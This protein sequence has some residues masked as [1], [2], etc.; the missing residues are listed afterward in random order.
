VILG[1]GRAR[2]RFCKFWFDLNATPTPFPATGNL[3][4]RNQSERSSSEL[5]T[6]E[7]LM[8]TLRQAIRTWT[9]HRFLS[10]A[11]AS[12]L[13]LG[14]GLST[15][16]FTVANSVVFRPL[17][18]LN[19]DRL[20]AVFEVN[21]RFG[22]KPL[23]VSAPDYKAWKQKALGFDGI[24]AVEI[25]LHNIRFQGT[26]Q[27]VEAGRAEPDFFSLL[28]VQPALGR[29][30]LEED[31]VPM[32]PSV[33]MLSFDCW[34]TRFGADVN[35]IGS[36][37]TVDDRLL[38]I[39]GVLPRTFYCSLSSEP[40]HPEVWIPLVPT[41]QEM[42]QHGP[43]ALKVFARLRPGDTIPQA[44]TAIGAISAQISA[45]HPDSGSGTG[46][47]VFPLQQEVVGRTRPALMVLIAAA[48]CL[49][50]IAC[51]DVSNLMLARAIDRQREMAVR[52]ALGARRSQLLRM[53]LIE[54]SLL[55]FAGGGAGV[56]L[57]FWSLPVI[58]R[59]VPPDVPRIDEVRI[60]WQ[61]LLFA[62]SVSLLVT[63]LFG[64]LPAFRPL[65]LNSLRGGGDSGRTVARSP[66]AGKVR[67]ALIVGQIALTLVLL[68][69][70][71]LMAN[72]LIRL[73]RVNP[74]FVTKDLF[75][76]NIGPSHHR[77][78]E[79]SKL[80]DFFDRV[81]EH[82]RSAPGVSAAAVSFPLP[83]TGISIK[84]GFT[85]EG[86]SDVAGEEREADFA[87]ISPDYFKT[88][89]IA[90]LKGRPLSERDDLASSQVAVISD[91]L[92]S[93]LWPGDEPIG[94]RIVLEAQP[95]ASSAQAVEV[96]GIAAD[97][98]PSPSE[99]PISTIY[100]SYR[101]NPW[102]SMYL[103]ARG[104]PGIVGLTNEMANSVN[105]IDDTRPL[106][107]MLSMDQRWSNLVVT[108]RFYMSVLGIFGLVALALALMGIYSLMTYL[109]SQRTRS[110][111]IRMAMGATPR[112]ILRLVVGEAVAL[113]M[114][115]AA[116][117][118]A[119][120]FWLTRLIAAFLF[121]I[122]PTD[123][124]TIALATISMIIMA[125]FASY[126]PARRAAGID[127]IE[128]LRSE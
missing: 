11:V 107:D 61:T 119:V 49:M 90:L 56:A 6:W 73:Y 77:I 108:P 126:F 50:L 42:A 51:A 34:R 106:G 8:F 12:S 55:A 63:I 28:G 91:T 113:A 125:L 4:L 38:T 16:I 19:P 101:Q 40:L 110:I 124:L 23:A 69:G 83:M 43:G 89:R 44:Q 111:G 76:M 122:Q 1:V 98:R 71:L 121:E 87:V 26:N 95:G 62:A 123:P 81:L 13:A 74:G 100:Q 48:A 9:T 102:P 67:G 46:V 24:S 64:V 54:S 116:V 78:S 72:S 47:A 120:A 25:G 86:E 85:V 70:A 115:G 59:L 17:P 31:D 128:A 20:V 27:Q 68:I 60:S 37:I 5:G 92:A 114:A 35:I 14:I 66:M 104:A 105:A 15:A 84:Q 117:G 10:L 57:A 18:F 103:V 45:Q 2:I 65:E 30:F 21:A 82:L 79:D 7:A 75:T 94:K 99:P 29:A 22:P 39:V 53:T 3:S 109:V 97:I 118:L 36:G 52:A 127:P 112:S 80:V 93:Q 88:M 41:P 32:G 96:V 33:A 58:I